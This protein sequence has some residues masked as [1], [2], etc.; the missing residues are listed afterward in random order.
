MNRK[1]WLAMVGAVG[2]A[3]GVTGCSTP[4]GGN[5]ANKDVETYLGPAAPAPGKAGDLFE[6]LD[7][8][9]DA[10][11]QLEEQDPSG[12]DNAK[13]ICPGGPGDKVKPPTYP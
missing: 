7:R 1:R 12:L 3:A 5:Y 9:S 6:Y 4:D 2:V 8:L 11:C 13:R 10:V